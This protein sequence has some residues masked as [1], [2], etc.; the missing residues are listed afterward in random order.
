LRRRS[1]FARAAARSAKNQAVENS[2]SIEFWYRRK[3]NLAPT[4]PIFLDATIEQ[5][6]DDFYAWRAYENPNLMETDDEAYEEAVR[7]L[8][9]GE[10]GWEDV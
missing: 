9:A 10:D 3:Y 6:L 2:K 4:D 1:F 5:M 8:L 7:K